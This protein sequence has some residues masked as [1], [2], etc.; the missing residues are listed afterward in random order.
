MTTPSTTCGTASSALEAALLQDGADGT[1][2]NTELVALTRPGSLAP[3]EFALRVSV[4]FATAGRKFS[5]RP[6]AMS[7]DAQASLV[8]LGLVQPTWTHKQAARACLLF[9]CA[10]QADPLLVQ[11]QANDLFYKGDSDERVVVL[12]CLTLLPPQGQYDLLATD[13]VRS[14]VTEVFEAIACDNAY[15]LH[16]FSEPAFNQLVMK[17]YFTD[18]AV[19]RIVGLAARRNPELRRMALDFA[20]ERHAASR[21]VP[22]DLDLVTA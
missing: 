16:H 2:L 7:A 1:W 22:A 12:R 5:S 18:V 9:T 19:H 20:A 13:A 15:P 11:R 8:E 17:A 14:H 6:L 3:S 21:P 10:A 4:A